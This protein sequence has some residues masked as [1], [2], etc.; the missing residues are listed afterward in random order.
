MTRNPRIGFIG[1]GLMGHGA[2]KNILARGGYPLTVLAHK[3]RAP[4]DHLVQRGATEA[5][6]AAELGRQSDIVFLCLPSSAV[7]EATIHGTE[8]LASGLEKGA[9][10]I[11][12]TTADP[13]VTRRIGADLAER[14]IALMDA[15]LGRTPKEAEAGTLST[16]VGGEAADL[17]R[18]RPVM[19][20]YADTIIHCGP[21][22]AG[23]TCKLVNNSITVGMAALIAEGFV[24]AAKVGVDLDALCSVL[25][26]GGADGRMWQMMAPWIREGD[27]SFL[28]GPIRGAAKDLRA[29]GLMAQSAGSAVFIAQAVNQTLSLAINQGQADAFLPRLPGILATLNGTR[30]R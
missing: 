4:V 14:G 8:G 22:G 15:A 28:K 13:M 6:T 25:S 29:Y 12:T 5:A 19:E 11:D 24:T 10:V 7:V 18:V 27:D 30:I 16:Y 21:L 17:A 1:V 3:N 23:T 20:C 26:A 9:M 2:A